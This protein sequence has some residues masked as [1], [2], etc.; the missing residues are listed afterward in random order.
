MLRI[1]TGKNL[2]ERNPDEEKKLSGGGERGQKGGLMSPASRI[3]A[4]LR[5]TSWA[6]MNTGGD[7]T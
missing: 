7:N 1:I 3:S 6:G 5:R 2:L 4:R